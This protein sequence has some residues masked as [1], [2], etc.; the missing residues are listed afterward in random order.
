MARAAKPWHRIVLG[1]AGLALLAVAL[2]GIAGPTGSRE[3]RAPAR[4]GLFTSLPLFWN[5][6]ASIGDLLR[7][8]APPH[9]ALAVLRRHGPVVPLDILA[10]G[11]DDRLSGVDLLI[12]AQ[13]RPLSPQENVV[14]DDWVRA[15]GRALLFV[16]PMLTEE[17]LH[18]PGDRRRPQDIAMLSPILARWGLV[19]RFDEDQAPG[20]RTTFLFGHP[21][22]VNLAGQWSLMPDAGRCNVLDG[23]IAVDCRIGEG[24]ILALTDAALLER[25]RGVQ[26]DGP[27]AMLDALVER[28]R[29]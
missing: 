8:D 6:S 20:E 4:I 16:D 2:Y 18:A 9:W 17:S 24:R 10:T 13:P 7:Q 27:A 19:L 5:E 22:P 14:L 1:V 29:S 23:G 12:L 15:G 25:E 11:P 21:F 3:E 28:V 26:A